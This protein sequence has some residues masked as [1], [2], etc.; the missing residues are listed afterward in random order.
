MFHGPLAWA[1]V[2][3][4]RRELGLRSRHYPRPKPDGL[5]G[6]S[7]ILRHRRSLPTI[8]ATNALWGACF[9]QPSATMPRS[10][11]PRMV[12][13]E[14]FS[15]GVLSMTFQTTHHDCRSTAA[16]SAAGV[17]CFRRFSE[18]SSGRSDRS[19][20]SSTAFCAGI[21]LGRSWLGESSRRW[22]RSSSFIIGSSATTMPRTRRTAPPHDLP[23]GQGVVAVL[24]GQQRLTALNIGLRGNIRE[25]N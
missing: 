6:S 19:P 20:A 1:A 25:Q 17:L 8:I 24:D 22:P 4:P 7:A 21:Q 5:A 14:R 11:R 23:H 15:R 9:A 10:G 3:R 16:H 13:A 18:S 2:Y 12:R